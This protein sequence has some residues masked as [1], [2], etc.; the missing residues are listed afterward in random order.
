[1]PDPS[2]R[3]D[4]PPDPTSQPP[5]G[6]PGQDPS[7]AARPPAGLPGP[8]S[9]PSLSSRRGR[10]LFEELT[11]ELS[12]E[13]VRGRVALLADYQRRVHRWFTLSAAMGIVVGV[14]VAAL[15]VL[16]EDLLLE[17]F[18]LHSP[19]PLVLVLPTVG[20]VLAHQALRTVPGV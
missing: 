15:H 19:W 7:P 14:G 2:P 13:A 5:A 16:I 12:L 18:V 20:L 8:A 11:G 10:P 1:M 17:R 6:S 4:Q 3:S 9:R